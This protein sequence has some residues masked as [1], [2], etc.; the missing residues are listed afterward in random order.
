M[1]EK[2][3][4]FRCGIN[5]DFVDSWCFLLRSTVAFNYVNKWRKE[6]KRN[7]ESLLP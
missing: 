4:I 7:E 6:I 3:H 5:R 1:K 2:H